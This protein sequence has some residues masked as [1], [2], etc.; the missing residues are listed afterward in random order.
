[1]RYSELFDLH[2]VRILQRLSSLAECTGLLQVEA[3]EIKAKSINW[4]SYLQ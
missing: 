4:Q 3:A 2:H 1:M